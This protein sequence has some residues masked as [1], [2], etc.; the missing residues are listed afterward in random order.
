MPTLPPTADPTTALAQWRAARPGATLAEIEHA[1]DA[2]FSAYPAALISDL[3]TAAPPAKR[4]V[5]PACGTPLQQVG[6]R[7]R[8]VRTAHEGTLTV[9]GPTYRCPACSGW[10]LSR[11]IDTSLTLVALDHARR[12]RPPAPGVIHHS[13]RGVQYAS[14]AYVD[15]LTATPARI[16]M[17]AVG[18]PYDNAKAESFFKTLKREE[19]YLNHDDSFADAAAKVPLSMARSSGFTPSRPLPL[20]IPFSGR[21]TTSTPVT[22]QLTS[23]RIWPAGAS[24]SVSDHTF[25]RRSSPPDASPL[26]WS[27]SD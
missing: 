14:A 2:Q 22:R 27:L 24:C 18:N 25:R 15:R 12:T 7:S 4:P 9:T 17:S 1:F 23:S 8:T 11:Q 6:T 20:P 16:S 19:V 21:L 10:R 5:R 3:A 26:R 13:D